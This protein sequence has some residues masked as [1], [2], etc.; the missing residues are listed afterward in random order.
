[1]MSNLLAP[2]VRSAM[3]LTMEQKEIL[4]VMKQLIESLV[5]SALSHDILLMTGTLSHMLFRYT[6]SSLSPASWLPSPIST[7]SGLRRPR[8][9]SPWAMNSG[10]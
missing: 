9:M 10:L 4:V 3:S 5:I 8:T 2:G 7:M 1:M 6:S